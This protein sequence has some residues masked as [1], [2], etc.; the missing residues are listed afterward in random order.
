MQIEEINALNNNINSMRDTRVK[1]E[2]NINLTLKPQEIILNL[3]GQKLATVAGPEI[4][5]QISDPRNG[6]YISED[7]IFDRTFGSTSQTSVIGTL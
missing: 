4:V 1:E 3:D 2:S 6:R 5:K 7:I